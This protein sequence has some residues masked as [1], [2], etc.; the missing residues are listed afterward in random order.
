LESP[1]R[2]ERLRLGI[3]TA[4]ELAAASGTYAHQISVAERGSGPI[5][6]KVANWLAS[7]GTD[8]EALILAHD[9]FRQAQSDAI[10]SR[11]LNRAAVAGATK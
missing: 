7:V 3:P 6:A 2:R 5:P 8:V 10:R 9:R 11:V 1:L 4:A